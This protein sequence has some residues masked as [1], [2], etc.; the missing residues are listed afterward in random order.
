MSDVWQVVKERHG[1]LDL[2]NT[3]KSFIFSEPYLRITD[4]LSHRCEDKVV[5]SSS[6]WHCCSDRA[7]CGCCGWGQGWGLLPSLPCPGR[8]KH[9]VVVSRQLSWSA[10]AKTRH[11]LHG[12]SCHRS[13]FQDWICRRGQV[14]PIFHIQTKSIAEIQDL[15]YQFT[16][17]RL[18]TLSSSCHCAVCRLLRV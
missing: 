6:L 11:S 7:T 9:S 2:L 3:N 10:F 4:L 15:C 17:Q 14:S 18:R 8:R 1:Y 16:G 13:F 12:K 5:S